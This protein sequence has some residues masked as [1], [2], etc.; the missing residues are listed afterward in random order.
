MQTNSEAL[1]ILLVEDYEANILVTT[2]ILENFGYHYEVARNG[3]EA[4]ERFSPGKYSIIMMDVEMPVMNGYEVTRHIRAF[5]KAETAIPVAIIAMTAHAMKGDREKCIA[6][7][8][9]DYIAKPFSLDQLQAVLLKYLKKGA[10][11][12]AA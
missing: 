5:E 4:M 3:Q 12:K 8:M 6:A 2:I 1:P 9:D 11:G 7:G 10:A